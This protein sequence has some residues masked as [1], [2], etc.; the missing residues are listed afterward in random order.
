MRSMRI[1]EFSTNIDANDFETGV[2]FVRYTKGSKYAM[3]RLVIK[4]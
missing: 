2:Y 1:N 4:K 3:E